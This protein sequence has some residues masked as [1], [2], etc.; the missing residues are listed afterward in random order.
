MDGRATVAARRRAARD[1]AAPYGGVLSRA[2]LR[3]V[4]VDHRMVRREVSAERWATHGVQTVATF[5]GPLDALAHRWRG[6]WEV[7]DRV[8]AVDGVT[9]L[10]HAGMTGYDDDRVHVSVR[11]TTEVEDVEGVVIHKVVRRVEGELLEGGLPRT[12][13]A[14]AAVRAAHWA[15]SDRQAALLLVLP[16]QQRLCTGEQLVAAADEVR[17]RTR[18]A[19]VPRLARDVADGAHSLGELDVVAAC[20]RRGLPEPSNQTVRRLPGGRA[21]LDV[22]WREARLVVEVDGAGHVA[23]LQPG[24]DTL[25]QNAVALGDDLVLRVG[26]LGWRLTPE[27]YL[28]Q[29]CAAYRSRLTRAA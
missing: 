16:V 18:R 5:T 12:R 26:L 8:A 10:H 28:D 11:H 23:G 29:I 21:Y 17:M 20:R 4:G 15:V 19:L 24:D 13:P 6:V 3:T 9:A 1:L 7:G 27:V 14:V 22:E 25:R 2:L